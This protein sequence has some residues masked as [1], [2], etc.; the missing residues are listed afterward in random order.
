MDLFIGEWVLTFQEQEIRG[1]Y[2]ALTVI[3]RKPYPKE[4]VLHNCQFQ[5][6]LKTPF[7]THVHFGFDCVFPEDLS[8]DAVYSQTAETLVQIALNGGHL[9]DYDMTTVCMGLYF[10]QAVQIM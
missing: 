7:I 3:P 10:V 8:N 1:E 2:D 6:D 9:A 5:A 4:V